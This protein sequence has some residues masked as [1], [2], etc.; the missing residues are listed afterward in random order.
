[1][2]R[3]GRSRGTKRSGVSQVVARE[4]EPRI[5]RRPR[6]GRGKMIRL[7][8]NQHFA[9]AALVDIESGFLV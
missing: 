9:T 1:M 3:C 4:N 8:V 7:K 5:S 2:L 6:L